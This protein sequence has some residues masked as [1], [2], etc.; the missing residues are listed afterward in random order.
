MAPRAYQPSKPAPMAGEYQELNALGAPTGRMVPHVGVV[1]GLIVRGEEPSE[2]GIAALLARLRSSGKE[3]SAA[4]EAEAEIRG[5]AH[6]VLDRH[7]ELLPV[8]AVGDL[9]VG[10]EAAGWGYRHRAALTAE[11]FVPNAFSAVPGERLYRTGERARWRADGRLELIGRED[12]SFRNDGKQEDLV[13]IE[14]ALL[15]HE[16]V[17]EA[18]VLQGEAALR[19]PWLA[20]YV[21]ERVPAAPAALAGNF[22]AARSVTAG[23][24]PAEQFI[25]QLKRHLRAQPSLS[26]LPQEWLVLEALP[27]TA[28]GAVDR[29]SLPQPQNA[30]PKYVAPRT[31]L[32]RALVEVW[33]EQLGIERVGV[34]ESYFALGGDSIRSI[35]LVAQARERGVDFSIKDLFAH[36]TVSGRLCR[37]GR[38]EELR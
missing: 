15:S 35:A 33:Q 38:R 32:E 3:E 24:M 25:A 22:L 11:R 17:R 20:A 34:E 9:Y 30:G 13:E 4:R 1:E 18:V 37:A 28:S 8:G 27:R 7:G 31:E 6:Y 36:P 10:G 26:R 21:V 16:S 23:A 12:P 5:V 14:R 2:G 29:S 19:E